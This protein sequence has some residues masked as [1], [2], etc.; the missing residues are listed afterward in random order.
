MFE[1]ITSGYRRHNLPQQHMKGLEKSENY[2]C[3]KTVIEGESLCGVKIS[4]K[5]A[6]LCKSVAM[7]LCCCPQFALV[8]TFYMHSCYSALSADLLYIPSQV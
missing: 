5:S 4:I 8:H 2:I 6:T 3:N 7:I 1:K